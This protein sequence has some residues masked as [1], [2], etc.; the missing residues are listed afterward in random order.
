MKSLILLLLISH[1]AVYAQYTTKKVI[2]E[3]RGTVVVLLAG[4]R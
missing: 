2:V 4:G 3:G 1:T